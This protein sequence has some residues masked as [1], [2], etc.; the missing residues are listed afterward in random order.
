MTDEQRWLFDLQGFIVLRNVIT[1]EHCE[2]LLRRLDALAREE[3]GP[4]LT[5]ARGEPT[6]RQ[7][8]HRIIEKDDLFLEMLDHEPVIAVIQELVGTP[9]MVDNDGL[10]VPRTDEAGGWH[11]GVGA[12]GF[13]LI[14]G[15]FHCTMVKA[16]YYLTDVGKGEGPTRLVPGSHKT[17]LPHPETPR[18]GTVPGMI[19]LETPARSVLIFSE[20]VLHAGNAN[21][22]D[23]VRKSLI[24]NYGPSYVEPWE[25]YRPSPALLGR[26][27]SPLRRQLLGLG[28]VYSTTEEEGRLRYR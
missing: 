17:S 26:E 5:D 4:D 20:A 16:F 27:H 21:A 6:R 8:V 23:K 9:K 12:H 18:E 24:Y 14:N 7:S 15:R 1:E 22:S 19:E 10:L 28:R 3:R 13:H 11:R 2:R 25:G